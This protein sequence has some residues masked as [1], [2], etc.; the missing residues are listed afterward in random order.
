[1]A[2][3]TRDAVD[4]AELTLGYG[5]VGTQPLPGCHRDRAQARSGRCWHERQDDH[6]V[7]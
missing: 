6:T 1:M 7:R 5:Y 3:Q 4:G 2:E